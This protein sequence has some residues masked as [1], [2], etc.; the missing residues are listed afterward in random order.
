MMRKP[1]VAIVGRP[2]VGKSTF[3]NKMIGERISIVD[4][5]PGVTRDRIYGDADW[6]NYDFKLIDTGGIE[7]KSNDVILAQMRRQ[8]EMAI[9][10]ADVIIFMTDGKVGMT[11]VDHEIGDMLRKSNTPVVVTVN[12]MD[13]SE[14]DPSFY[15]FYNLGFEDV[16]PISSLNKMRLGDMLDKVVSYFSSDYIQNY[17]ESAI[18]I[19]ILGKPNVGKSTLI[20]SILGEER[21]IV[22]DIAGTT[23]D[24][25]DTPFYYGDQEYVF[26]DTA[27]IRRKRSIKE[28]IEHYSVI[29]SLSAIERSDIS[30]IVVD[31]TE[32]VTEQDKR[33][34]G[35]AHE[36]GKGIIIVINKWD[37]IEDKE[38]TFHEFYK[39]VRNEFAFITYAPIIF[40]SALTKQRVFKLFKLINIVSENQ[41]L[42]I[43]TGKLNDILNEAIYRHQPP[44]KKGKRLKIYYATQ[45][46]VKPPSFALFVNDKDL[47]HFSYPRYLSNQLREHF[48]FVGTKL[49]IMLRNKKK[50]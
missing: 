14:L 24:A 19:S 47:C 11:S 5:T 45:V 18:K 38:Q 36:N 6:L 1:I 22:S 43:S 44:S 21:V 35:H 27:G 41:N 39:E 3:F 28:N 25:V 29:R 33:I 16:F 15:E 12:K 20:N 8:A 32:G 7:P 42:R 34:A 46:S 49:N 2:N 40:I 48:E 31:A 13:K 50:R 30:L 37:L 26:I 4:D 23:R 10:T 9:E 17:D